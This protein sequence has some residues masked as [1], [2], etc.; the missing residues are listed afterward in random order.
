MISS[1]AG[2]LA[3]AARALRKS[4][5]FAVAATALL[6]AGIGGTATVFSLADALL[7]RPLSLP[8]PA[9]MVRVVSVLPGRPSVSYYPYAY[10][11]EWRARTRSLSGA[12]AEADVDTNLTENGGS[13]LLRTGI[14]SGDYFAA[15][16]A[17]PAVGRLLGA[18]DEWAAQ[19]ELPAV[20]SYDFWHS[21]FRGHPA[22]LGTVLRLNGQPF[23]VVGILPRR[24]NGIAVES[25]P[26]VWVP[27]IAGKYL[28][29][30]ADPKQ[31]CRWGIGGR[32]RPGVTL[33]Q[34]EAET[35]AALHAAMMAAESRNKPLSEEA[36]KQIELSDDRLES[37]EHGVSSLRTR[38][39]T[40]LLALFGG[41]A[42]LLLLACA[43]I[44]GLLLARAAGRERE[45][46]VRAALG[47]TRVRLMRHWLAE[48]ALLVAAGGL[49]GLLLAKAGLV[50]APGA[51]PAIRDLGT[52]LVPVSL[53]VTLD[54]RVF[55]FTLAICLAAALLAG[56][57]PAWHASR[58]NLTD[59]LK[60]N[61]P[62]PR[63]ARLRTALTVAQVAIGTLV[64]AVS[65]LLVSTL[66]RLATAPAGFDRDHV[67]TFTMDTEFARY[68]TE[69][70]RDLA[71]R[72]ER[73]ARAIPGAAQ[74]GTASRSLMRGSGFKTAVALPG[75]R[76]GHDLNASTNKVSP[77]WFDAMGMTI[78]A[79]RGL[80]EADGTRRTP[81]PVV[82]NQSFVRRF[83]PDGQ[84]LGRQFGIGRDQV[85]TAAF[86]IVGVVSDARYRSFREPFQPT[87][88][89]CLC[90][91]SSGDPVFQ[92][93]VRSVGRPESVIGSV[94][95]AMRQIDPRLPF[96][97]VRTMRS[98][99]DDSLWAERTLAAVGSGLSLLAALI[100]CVGLYGLLSYTLAQRRAEIAIRIALGARPADIGRATLRN[101]IV[102]LLAGAALGIAAAVPAARL[103]ASVLFDVGPTDWLAHTSAVALML[104]AGLVAAARPARRAS[105][106]DPWDALRG[107]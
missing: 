10:F 62:D 105:R 16:R 101:S 66:H 28:G 25:G 99:V 104:L 50:R 85:V 51:L 102:I 22:A 82:V 3:Y 43:N 31:C 17:T 45:M 67:V 36:R 76:A 32:L 44:A 40:A 33:H 89:S 9:E 81:A 92:L 34:A 8:L 61:A 27:L 14:V 97:E 88:F 30:G 18:G 2:D 19:G 48:S 7:F 39:G 46:A 26:S 13:R 53:D 84:P 24:M 4:P 107:N 11:E 35:I 41:A 58:A 56:L 86:E 23:V 79:G 100:A 64:L 60:S 57:G 12:F 98:D 47:A 106:M 72:L 78:L 69:Q 59:S 49:V 29:L 21:Q 87:L 94:E 91:S 80:T 103:M 65:A 68:T 75:T 55:A 77:A 54:G 1:I 93:E 74:A 37:I 96:R 70:N 6:A 63:R 90:G 20:L 71:A 95:S 38:F 52:W 73:E 5:G 42:L 15:L 83:F